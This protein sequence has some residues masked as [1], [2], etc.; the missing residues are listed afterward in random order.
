M[1]LRILKKLSKRA[2]PVLIKRY[3]Y[4]QADFL[5][6]TSDDP[7]YAGLAVDRKHQDHS[8][9]SAR[10]FE[11]AWPGTPY[12]GEMSGWECPEWSERT[13]WVELQNMVGGEVMVEVGD[14]DESG[15]PE[16][17]LPAFYLSPINVFAYLR[18]DKKVFD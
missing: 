9:I 5:T 13:A 15:C 8:R 10:G 6:A 2:V 17:V 4:R 11:E 3:S 18:G 1:N 12:V 7:P 14:R 16:N